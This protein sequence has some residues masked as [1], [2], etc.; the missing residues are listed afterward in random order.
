MKQSKELGVVPNQGF[1]ETVA[2]PTPDFPAALGPLA[3]GVLGSSQWV[4]QIKGSDKYFG[5]AADYTAGF[6][7]QFGDE[8]EYHNAEATAACLAFVLAVEKAGSA[9]AA[10]VRDAMAS[11]DAQ[12][13][14]GQIKFDASGQ[15]VTKPM[16]V[17]QVQNGKPVTVWPKEAAEKPLIWP[18]VK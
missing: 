17:I 5:S 10:K 2:P 3:E 7:K 11:L 14:F 6:K 4:P 1:G 18:A 13:F 12:T 9:D 16:A 15:N 8:P